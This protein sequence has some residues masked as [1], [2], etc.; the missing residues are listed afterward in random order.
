MKTKNRL[1]AWALCLALIFAL[2]PQMSL[3]AHAETNSGN[4]GAEGDNLTWT[5]D[6]ETGVL[7]ISG[8]GAMADYAQW[9]RPWADAEESVT[10]VV[11]PA[12]LTHIG[13]NAFYGFTG[14]TGV[15][16]PTS[17]T[18]IG[19]NAFAKCG[20]TSISFP[21]GLT[22]IGDGAFAECAGLTT[23]SLPADMTDVRWAAFCKCTGLKSVTLPTNL[24]YVGGYAFSGCTGLTGISLPTG[25]KSLGE[26]AFSDCTG[27][28][29]ISLP[30][31]LFICG[32]HVFAG[33]TGLKTMSFPNSLHYVS[34]G[35]FSGCTGLTSMTLHDTIQRIEEEAFSGCTGLTSINLPKSVEQIERGAFSGCTGLTSISIPAKVTTISE[36]VFSGCTGLKSL[37]IPAGVT[38]ILQSAFSGCAGLTSVKFPE[39]L[40]GIG[41]CAFLNC[42]KLTKVTIPETVLGVGELSFGYLSSESGAATP[43]SGFTI[44]GITGS[45]AEEYALANGFTFVSLGGVR[46]PFVD[47]QSSDFFFNPV[48]W[49]LEND[50]TGGIDSTHFG[51]YN[52]VQR[53]DAMV[54][55][56][57]AKGRPGFTSTAKTFKDVKKTHWAYSAVMWAVE[58]GITGGTDASHFSPAQTCSRSEILQFLYAAERKP[59]YTIQNPYSDVKNKHW[60]KDGAIWAY[61]NGLEK[62]DNGK[63][64][65]MTPCTRAYVVVY[66]YRYITKQELAQ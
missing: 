16:L 61:Q 18:T 38:Q 35:A 22:T 23:V 40:K 51:P 44:C 64:N 11:L 33:C 59:G 63:F 20:L 27:L 53:A 29:G 25:V 54:F 12:G 28:T 48:M 17:L 26:G 47:V 60:Y 30:E 37:S 4:C 43:M 6:T 2:A 56:W 14:V 57:A 55:F 41:W 42:P 21:T 13:S 62:G 32:E 36:D 1:V 52:T 9:E 58:N 3:I 5:L 46:N 49:A 7:T 50:V 65:A 34:A 39:S 19:D 24:Q 66:L 8:S 45:A 31:S 10:T 15:S